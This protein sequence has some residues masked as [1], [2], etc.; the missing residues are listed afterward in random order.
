MRPDS[1]FTSILQSWPDK[2]RLHSFWCG[3]SLPNASRMLCDLRNSW[4]WVRHEQVNSPLHPDP[5]STVVVAIDKYNKHDQVTLRQGSTIAWVTFTYCP[6]AEFTIAAFKS[7]QL[8]HNKT[9][10]A[11]FPKWHVPMLCQSCLLGS[12]CNLSKLT[13]CGRCMW[14]K[15]K[16]SVWTGTFAFIVIWSILPMNSCWSGSPS[17]FWIPTASKLWQTKTSSFEATG[18]IAKTTFC[19]TGLNQSSKSHWILTLNVPIAN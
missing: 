3:S 15:P 2:A 12:W 19:W 9:L 17:A 8:L 16:K 14:R 4:C 13:F 7:L 18:T 10:I 5:E 11:A 1:P 6:G